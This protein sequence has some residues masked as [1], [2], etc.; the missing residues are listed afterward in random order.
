LDAPLPS[1]DPFPGIDPY[2]ESQAWAD[3]HTEFLVT[4]RG[5]LLPILPDHYTAH[6]ETWLYLEH[7]WEETPVRVRPDLSILRGAPAGAGP[8]RAATLE[9]TD[10]IEAPLTVR[11]AIP[12]QRTHRRIEIRERGSR[13]V[14]TV[15]ELLSPANKRPGTDGFREFRAKRDAILLSDT[16][17]VELDLLRGGQR[18]R[19]LDP[20]PNADYFAVISHAVRRPACS[21]WAWSLRDRLPTIGIPISEPDVD[22]EINLQQVFE[23][24][25]VH[26]GYRRALRYDR[27]VEPRLSEADTRWVRE[28]LGETA[29]DTDSGER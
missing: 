22:L 11:M 25:Y 23:T 19:M 20:L 24:A 16:H 4:L 13:G 8:S 29:I 14:V 15:I 27:D 21:V 28:R 3:F 17:L 6:L 26:G 18:T 9:L 5:A 10:T 7:E 1:A 12:E 2:L